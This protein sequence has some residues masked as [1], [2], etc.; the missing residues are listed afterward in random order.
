MAIITGF[1]ICESIMPIPN[2]NNQLDGKL[3]IEA[4]INALNFDFLPTHYSLSLYLSL[5]DIKSKGKNKLRITFGISAPFLLDTQDID[6]AIPDDAP[7]DFLQVALNMD[8]KN[9]K[10]EQEGTYY[11]QIYHNGTIVG[12]FPFYVRKVEK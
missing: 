3:Q 10:F 7:D 1:T 9:L 12:K 11:T 8:L 5:G 2:P 6:I 4:P